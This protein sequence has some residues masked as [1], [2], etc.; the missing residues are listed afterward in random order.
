VEAAI[1]A[2]ERGEVS[3]V[4]LTLGDQFDERLLH[5]LAARV[6]GDDSAER[7]LGVRRSLRVG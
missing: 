5:G 3:T 1:G 2:G 7:G 6:F 4:A